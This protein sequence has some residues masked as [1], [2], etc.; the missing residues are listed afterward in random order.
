MLY[1]SEIIET[2]PPTEDDLYMTPEEVAQRLRCDVS[3]LANLRARGEG[4]P[5]VKPFG[6]R[7][8]YKM[9]DVLAVETRGFRGFSWARL[10]AALDKF[11]DLKPGQCAKL[12]AH[13]KTEMGKP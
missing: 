7:V 9:A 10:A 3:T 4:I 11:E 5:Y 2:T 13:L 1:H 12:L 8:L 6:G